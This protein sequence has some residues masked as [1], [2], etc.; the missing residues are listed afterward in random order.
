MSDP[1]R[2]DPRDAW[3]SQAL[4][5]A[6]DAD[7]T[8]PTAL[9]DSILA[10]ARAA[11][12]PVRR[13]R[14]RPS[15]FVDVLRSGWIALA[16]PPVA[17]GFA[18]VMAA[19]IVGL[20]WWDRPMDEALP[21][22]PAPSVRTAPVAPPA[23]VKQTEAQAPAP[24]PALA[25]APAAE[26]AT[27]RGSAGPSTERTA[28]PLPTR[29]PEPPAAFPAGEPRREVASKPV[30]EAKKA[31][32]PSSFAGPSADA[33]PAES[34]P[35]AA[36]APPPE[37][38][39][40]A[41]RMRSEIA[42]DRADKAVA[43]DDARSNEPAPAGTAA[44]R[45]R[46]AVGPRANAD[47]S[48]RE[49]AAPTTS[50]LAS[51]LDAIAREPQRWTRRSAA[52]SAAAIDAAWRDWLAE[53]DAAVAGR[54]QRAGASASPGDDE[55]HDALALQLF[56]DGRLAATLRLDGRVLQLD[57]LPGAAPEHWQARLAADAASRLAAGRSRLP[58]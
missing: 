55:G 9:S 42:A 13:P 46:N 29:K 30:D 31:R 35:A 19:T 10:K 38:G 26:P 56:V 47:A 6:P 15:S 54:W 48:E 17:A 50:P 27:A 7:A 40:G 41:G 36:P 32:A 53:V 14:S 21:P 20:M 16:R 24:A 18:S 33:Q 49:Q 1:D 57:R 52:G 39:R 2:D 23:A 28:A 12:A 37:A 44:L 58:P 5:H 25:Q 8:P 51:L 45:Q 11:A 3:L 4:R 22:A 34:A 43:K